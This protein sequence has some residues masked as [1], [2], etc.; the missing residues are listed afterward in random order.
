MADASGPSVAARDDLAGVVDLFGWLTRAELSRALSELAF[1]QRAEVDEAAIDA[2]IDLAVAEYALVP[3]PSAALSSAGSESASERETALAVGPAAF[4]T[5]PAG[6]EDLPHILEIPDREVDREALSD[7][8][9]ERLREEAV[10]AIGDSDDE[11]LET[12]ADVT[13]D[14]EAWAPVDVDPVRTRILAEVDEA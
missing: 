1:K 6:A 2:A 5:L 3:A 7:A 13:Y 8:V 12:L 11:Q 14:V 10:A 4:P 9:L